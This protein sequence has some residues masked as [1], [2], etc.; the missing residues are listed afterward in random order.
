MG[1]LPHRPVARIDR[2]VHTPSRRTFMSQLKQLTDKFWAMFEAGKVDEL[3]DLVDADCHFKMPG[4]DLHGR[5]QL[6]QMLHGYRVAF[7]DL[8]HTVRTHVESGDTIALE[9]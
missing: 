4:M 3:S 9:L 5:A 8:R 1:H 6:L 7:P 2:N